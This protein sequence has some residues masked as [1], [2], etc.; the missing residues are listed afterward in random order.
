[1]AT[2]FDT[3]VGTGTFTTIS[4]DNSYIWVG[5]SIALAIVIAFYLLRSIGLFVLAK[6]Q[7]VKHAYLAWIPLVW[8][9]LLCKLIGKV[10]LFN[11]PYEKI[12]IWL[13][14]RL[15]KIKFY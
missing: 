8:F 15:Y 1:M 13:C 2:T 14:C 5:L 9:Y 6:R 11:M 10:R 12:A 7:N 4:I 3:V